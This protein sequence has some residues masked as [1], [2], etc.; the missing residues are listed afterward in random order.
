MLDDEDTDGR[1]VFV[2]QGVPVA[3][4]VSFTD[5]FHLKLA[6][7]VAFSYFC[8]NLI[9]C[10]HAA[11]FPRRSAQVHRVHVAAALSLPRGRPHQQYFRVDIRRI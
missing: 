5:I 7:E 6:K 10:G 9:R 1:E 4:M 2:L 8:V 11:C 3:R